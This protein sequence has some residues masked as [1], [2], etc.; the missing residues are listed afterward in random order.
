MSESARFRIKQKPE[1]I[2]SG[3][4]AIHVERNDGAAGKGQVLPVDLDFAA[5][6]VD[7]L[8]PAM[9]VA[10]SMETEVISFGPLN[11]KST[12]L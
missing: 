10:G 5:S 4:C 12:S 1:R 2:H 9:L 8:N 7:R 11:C 6:E 3:S